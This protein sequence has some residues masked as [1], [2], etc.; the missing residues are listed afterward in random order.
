MNAKGKGMGSPQATRVAVLDGGGRARP[1]WLSC[2]IGRDIEFATGGLESYCF[3]NWQPVVFDALL[4]A[5]VVDFCDRVARRPSLEW[6]RDFQVQLPVHEPGRW[7]GR[8]SEKLASVLAFLSGDR[9]RFDFRHRDSAVNAPSQ[10]NL[11]IPA[12]S[13]A[14]LP[15]SDGLDSRTASALQEHQRGTPLIRVRLGSGNAKNKAAAKVKQPFAVVP[16]KLKQ[17]RYRFRES[18]GRCRGFKFTMLCGVA[19]SLSKASE[20][21][22]PESGQGALG[23][24][25]VTVGQGYEDYR[26]HPRFTARM[27]EFLA[28]LFGHQ[29]NFTF[30]RIWHT[31]GETLKEYADLAGD[32][33][34]DT[35][36]CW[37]Q[38][39]QV[40]VDGRRRQCGICAA[41]MLRRLSVHAAGLRESPETYVWENLSAGTFE[42]GVA[43]GFTSM[44][45]A[46]REYAIAGVLHMDHLAELSGSPEHAECIRR[47]ASQIAPI[48]GL[49]PE[50]AEE[51]LSRLLCQHALE[52]RNFIRSLDANSFVAKW[53]P[54]RERDAH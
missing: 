49:A 13:S 22:I 50:D 20:I 27:A 1:D 44:T 51:R 33:W 48:L 45:K 6:A 47:N 8:V 31:K 18:S 54:R 30:P 21:V 43:A 29:V 41:C 53:I 15:F 14:V 3:S 23:P 2:E 25:L 34:S 46:L 9:W 38:S 40:S 7:S 35:R 11:E 19:A 16:Y 36:S 12:P 37:Q 10:R 4:L 24:A 32:T 39:R 5:A 26:N 52:W 17:T 28:A 42:G